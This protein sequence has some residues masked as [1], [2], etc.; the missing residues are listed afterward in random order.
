MLSTSTSQ[1]S[2]Q[3]GQIPEE[4]DAK[5]HPRST[6]TLAPIFAPKTKNSFNQS[7]NSRQRGTDVSNTATPQT[8]RPFE[9]D[10]ST[11]AAKRRKAVNSMV[12][13]P[14]A[15]KLRPKQLSEFI[16]QTHLMQPGSLLCT[17]LQNKA[18]WS[19]ILWGPPG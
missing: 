9:E 3:P 6:A 16:G 17:I 12:N 19:I 7:L 5:K 14:L 11:P 1:E 13:V 10:S 15:E 2:S 18:T 8:K 4:T